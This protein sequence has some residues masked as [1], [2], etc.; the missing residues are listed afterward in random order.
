M[1]SISKVV[2]AVMR[3]PFNFIDSVV[4]DIDTLNQQEANKPAGVTAEELEEL[5]LFREAKQRSAARMAK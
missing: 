2:A 1:G 5:R 3:H 4:K